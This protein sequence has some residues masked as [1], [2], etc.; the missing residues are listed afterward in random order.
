M[1][2]FSFLLFIPSTEGS[3]VPIEIVQQRSDFRQLVRKLFCSDVLPN[4]KSAVP[5]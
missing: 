2:D 4:L 3:E 5:S 1:T